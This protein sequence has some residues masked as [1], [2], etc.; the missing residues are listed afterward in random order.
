M[1]HVHS[2]DELNRRW[3]IFLDQEYQKEAHAEIKEYYES[4]GASVALCGI[5]PEQ[6]RM[7]D[8]RGLFF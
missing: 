2:V 6:E 8:S 4:C 5:T 7:R 3:K 1:A